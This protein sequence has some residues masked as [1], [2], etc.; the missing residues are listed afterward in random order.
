MNYADGFGNVWHMGQP[1][2]TLC[3]RFRNFSYQNT[4]EN[5]NLSNDINENVNISGIQGESL[6]KAEV[7]HDCD[8]GQTPVNTDSMY[9]EHS[10]ESLSKAEVIHD[11]DIGQTPVNTDSMYGEHSGESLSKAE[12]IHDCDIGQTPGESLSKAE[13]IHD[14]D[15]GQTPVN[16]DSMYGEHSG[17]SLS[18]AEVIHDCDIGQTPVNT[19]SMYGEHSGESLSNAEVI[20]DCDIGQTSVNT[21]S[22][23]G[24]HSGESLSNAEV[25]HDCDI[26]QTPVNTD[27]MYG[28]HSMFWKDK[29]DIPIFE[30]GRESR[31]SIDEAVNILLKESKKVQLCSTHPLKVRENASF[32]I[33]ISGYRNWEDIKT[34]MNGVFNVTLRNAT[35][36]ISVHDDIT[37]TKVGCEVLYKRREKLEDRAQY[38]VTQHFK[39]NKSSP[40]L[41]RSI[42]MLRDHKGNIVNNCALL[43]YYVT[44]GKDVHLVVGSHGN[45]KRSKKPFYPCAKSVHEIM[46]EK[47]ASE[48]PSKVYQFLHG[49][50]GGPMEQANA[51][52]LPRSKHQLYDVKWRMKKFADPVDELL[53]YAKHKDKTIVL[54]HSDVP[55]DLWILGDQIMC[56]DLGK[57]TSSSLLSFPFSVDPTFN[58]GSFEVTPIVYKHLFLKSKATGEP[59][60]FLGPTM[61]HHKK[62][63]STFKT[64]SSVCVASCKDLEVAK[65]FVTDGEVGLFQA[66][67][68]DIPLA[69]HLRC[70]KHFENN[71][72]EKLRSIGIQ[73][74]KDQR[75]FLQKVFGM[76]GKSK[77]ILDAEDDI[78]LKVL[79]DGMKGDVDAR[80]EMLL[81]SKREEYKPVS[82]VTSYL[83]SMLM[84]ENMI[85]NVRRKAG[86][87]NG[88]DGNPM[89]CYTNMSESMNHILKRTKEVSQSP[90]TKRGLN[91]LQFTKNVFEVVVE[92]QRR[93]LALSVANLSDIY[94]LADVAQHCKIGQETWFDMAKEERELFIKQFHEMSI[95]SAF[96]KKP[97]RIH[98]LPISERQ[99][100]LDLSIDLVKKLTEEFSYSLETAS[101]IYHS[102]LKLV[103]TPTAV[104]KKTSLDP[105]LNKKY[106]VATIHR[107]HGRVECIANKDHISCRCGCFKF[108]GICK[109]SIAVAELEGILQKHLIN[110]KKKRGS[111]RSR[112]E[113]LEGNID[114]EY[115]GKKGQEIKIDISDRLEMNK[116]IQ[117]AMMSV[118]RQYIT[119]TTCLWFSYF[120]RVQSSVRHVG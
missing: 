51:G 102:A 80:E 42:F 67:E 5:D 44:G 85:G 45:A 18:K 71:C 59:P 84:K 28:E 16:T 50:A 90:G 115:A 117:P 78:E 114:K 60:V 20:H 15:I 99:E 89:R 93:E 1:N 68:S 61:I 72:R 77:G 52:Y 91:K 33:D 62:D 41:V 87:P 95:E 37:G 21:D 76:K 3:S 104:Q 53:V 94:E 107:K 118:T 110:I 32:L 19:D 23:Y 27:S 2:A 119:M 25:I 46:Q 48:A 14:C 58:F 74:R 10:G 82:M 7:I 103:N 39:R 22:M 116:P 36:T 69:K 73:A 97:L 86:L 34:D 54:H 29:C 100:F 40:D 24:E 43:Q 9:G 63:Y 64:L 70:F 57:F 12:V 79:L 108:D 8:I 26:G 98:N 13:V 30:T 75:F 88:P 6:S 65:G 120:L 38:H 11:C 4:S 35:W 111:K 55:N 112:T 47:V 101:E 105:I 17:E 83:T 49:E 56:H 106:E 109:H 96:A 81:G 31:Y 92:E 113:L 66:F